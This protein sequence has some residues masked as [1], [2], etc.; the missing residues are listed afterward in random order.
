M[1]LTLLVCAILSIASQFPHT[2]YV[3]K[4]GSN[5]KDKDWVFKG[6]TMVS[7]KRIQAAIFSVIIAS[8]IMCTVIL[9]LH[10]VAIF[11]TVIEMAIGVI[12]VK[13]SMDHRKESGSYK[14]PN[15][16]EKFAG[17]FM[18]ILIPFCIYAF[19]FMYAEYE[20]ILKFINML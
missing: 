19:S 15:K 18:A 13:S 11:W 4:L 8:A 14:T 6:V 20:N 17:Y 10:Y 9:K 3:V 12:Y 7:P 16:N 2:D 5:L 1:K